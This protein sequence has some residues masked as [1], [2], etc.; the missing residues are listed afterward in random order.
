MQFMT[1]ITRHP[2]NAGTPPPSELREAQFEKVRSLYADGFLRQI[3]FRGDV[4]GACMIVEAA[5]IDDVLEKLSELPLLRAGFLQ[6]PMIVPLKPYP[7]FAPR[8]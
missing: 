4:R 8:S 3:W 7:G 1:L 2:D 5:S 6:P